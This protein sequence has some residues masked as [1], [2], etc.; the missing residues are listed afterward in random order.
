MI[1]TSP[2][3]FSCLIFLLRSSF[4]LY[5]RG[6]RGLKIFE[7]LNGYYFFKVHCTHSII[8]I[9][10]RCRHEKLFLNKNACKTTD[11]DLPIII[12]YSCKSH[13]W[14][15]HF[16]VHIKSACPSK[17]SWLFFYPSSLHTF[18]SAI[19]MGFTKQQKRGE[20]KK[21]RKNSFPW[22]WLTLVF[23]YKHN[24]YVVLSLYRRRGKEKNLVE[25]EGKKTHCKHGEMWV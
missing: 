22:L 16:F 4:C 6:M 12:R 13:A 11:I 15:N 7:K 2:L 14:N 10:T 3:S 9:S 5:R 24:V 21:K 18:H 19:G 25:G 20:K 8:I 1:A 17:K 23:S